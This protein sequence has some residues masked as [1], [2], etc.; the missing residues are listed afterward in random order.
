MIWRFL[1]AFTAV[2]LTSG[3]AIAT[4]IAVCDMAGR[5]V[6][7]GVWLA[8]CAVIAGALVRTPRPHQESA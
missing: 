7:I 1:T 5:P 2:A 4:G 8:I 6:A 3:T